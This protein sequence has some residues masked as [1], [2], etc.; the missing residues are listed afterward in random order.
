ME[1]SKER[2]EEAITI[3][4]EADELPILTL[5]RLWLIELLES[6]V[7]VLE[8]FNIIPTTKGK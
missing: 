1:L 8:R 3:I 4:A 2:Y 6:T 5:E 7:T